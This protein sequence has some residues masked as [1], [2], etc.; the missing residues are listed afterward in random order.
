MANPKI[1]L[2]KIGEQNSYD[3]RMLIK[4][5]DGNIRSNTKYYF[6]LENGEKIEGITDEKGY[7]QMIKTIQSEQVDIHIL[8]TEIINID[9]I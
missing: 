9:E 6:F 2:P 5:K 4:D 7:T 3:L 8:D 1:S